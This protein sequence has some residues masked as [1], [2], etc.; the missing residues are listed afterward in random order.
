[1]TYHA[2]YAADITRVI[3]EKNA[4]KGC[5]CA[6]EVRTNRDGSFDARDISG[7]DCVGGRARHLEEEA[8][9]SSPG[10]DVRL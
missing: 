9:F 6:D 7:T 4:T 5:E 10:V 2:Q 1:M 3:A 8:G